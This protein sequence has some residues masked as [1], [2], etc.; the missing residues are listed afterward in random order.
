[1][2]WKKQTKNDNDH[3]DDDDVHTHRRT[4]HTA[5]ALH[6]VARYRQHRHVPHSAHPLTAQGQRRIVRPQAMQKRQ[7]RV[8]HDCGEGREAGDREAGDKDGMSLTP[9][10]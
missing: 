3:D 9:D 5:S 10:V 4:L 8:A 6:V 1:M 7:Y 2:A